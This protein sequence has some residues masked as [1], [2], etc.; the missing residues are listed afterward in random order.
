MSKRFLIILAVCVAAFVGLLLFNKKDNPSP[1]ATQAA[2]TNHNQGANTTGVTL[3]EYGDFQCPACAS[4]YPVLKD[5][6]AKYGDKISFQFRN[7]P[8]VSIHP[9]AMAAH[10]AA[11]A[12]AKQN[13]FWEMHD[14]LYERWA[15]WKDSTSAPTIFESYAQELGLDMTKY[16]QDV[17]DPATK[18][19]IDADKAE[20]DKIG[21]T[22][23]PTFVL[24][25][26]KIEDNPRDVEGFSKLIDAAI[27]VKNPQ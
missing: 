16:R 10:R 18:A 19:V 26:K 6:K 15:S 13:K 27:K 23:T 12:A 4:Y 3:I 24:D 1:T 2:T 21:V 22:G 5:V 9:N 7:Y 14:M 8:L 11:E 17:A 25:G 20:G